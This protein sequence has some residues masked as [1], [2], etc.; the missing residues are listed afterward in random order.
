MISRTFLPKSL[1][2][3]SPVRIFLE[4]FTPFASYS[5]IEVLLHI[6]EPFDI[7]ILDETCSLK[8]I[9]IVVLLGLPNIRLSSSSSEIIISSICVNAYSFSSMIFPSEAILFSNSCFPNPDNEI[10][11]ISAIP[12]AWT[13]VNPILS[14]NSVIIASLSPFEDLI[15]LII[16]SILE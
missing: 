2:A 11:L 7:S 8:F 13:F 1:T 12:F 10:K 9:V 3:L 5:P 14:F 4:S 16:S 6:N 15:I